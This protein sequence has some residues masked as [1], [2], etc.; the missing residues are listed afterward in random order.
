MAA[1]KHGVRMVIIPK[2]NESDLW[3]VE[4]VVKEHVE[5]VTVEH[6]DEVFALS[7]R[8][9]KPAKAEQQHIRLKPDD[10]HARRNYE[11]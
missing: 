5:F 1:Y 4:D 11:I 7:L 8:E 3:D 2:D 9:S 6:L 10:A